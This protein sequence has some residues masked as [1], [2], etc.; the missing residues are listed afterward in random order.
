MRNFI[1]VVLALWP[2]LLFW[3]AVLGLGVW[4]ARNDR[5]ERI[6]TAV[7]IGLISVVC[8]GFA[9]IGITSVPS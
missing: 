2:W 1:T 3:S 6:W 8:V 5:R 7:S 9:A 4:S